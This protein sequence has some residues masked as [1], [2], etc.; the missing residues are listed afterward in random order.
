MIN[1]PQV[2]LLSL[3]ETAAL[4]TTRLSL[5]EYSACGISLCSSQIEID[6][7]L[8]LLKQFCYDSL[9]FR[10]QTIYVRPT[11]SPFDKV[12]NDLL[13]KNLEFFLTKSD[14]SS[15]LALLGLTTTKDSFIW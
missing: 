12:V 5:G 15:A 4:P 3:D 9:G 2:D 7:V 1:H 11:S 8:S 10:F 6:I 13:Y 14:S